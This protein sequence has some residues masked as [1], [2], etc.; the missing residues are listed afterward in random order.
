MAE[1]MHAKSTYYVPF[2]LL[3][4]I[5]LLLLWAVHVHEEAVKP[6]PRIL[7]REFPSLVARE[8]PPALGPHET[9]QALISEIQDDYPFVREIVVFKLRKE[10]G[11]VPVYPPFFARTHPAFIEGHQEGYEAVQLLF[12][13]QPVGT[14]YFKLDR[15]RPRLFNGALIGVLLLLVGYSALGVRALHKTSAQLLSTTIALQEKQR[16]L[17]HLERLALVGQVTA[18]LLHDLKKPLLNIRDEAGNLPGGETKDA[19]LGEV[20]LF[21]SMLRDLQLEGFLRRTEGKAE[22]VDIVEAIDRSI[23]LV[24][25]ARSAVQVER[26]I[27]EDLPFILGHHHKMVQVFSNVL[28]N[29]FEA[30]EGKGVVRI[31]ARSTRGRDPESEG[32]LVEVTIEDDGPGIRADILDH[33]FE[34]FF[35]ADKGSTG[36]GLYTAKSIVDELGGTIRAESEIGKGTRFAIRLPVGEAEMP[37]AD[38][39]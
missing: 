19:I 25:Y 39:R 30:L 8:V 26:S 18:G 36:L 16:Q 3:V 12:Q 11:L 10:H 20:G 34:P 13:E 22:F 29:A 4:V 38:G 2:G 6:I 14:V 33:I 28:L 23:R 32:S 1:L 31:T 17:L 35:S 24:S 37:S 9:L 5:G 27:P 21:L 7:A 15:T